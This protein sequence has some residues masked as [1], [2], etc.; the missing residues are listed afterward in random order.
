M[1]ATI[2]ALTQQG[3][4]G[5]HAGQQPFT[6]ESQLVNAARAGKHMLVVK[7]ASTVFLDSNILAA[8]IA[9]AQTWHKCSHCK[10]ACWNLEGL[11]F[12]AGIIA[13][14]PLHPVAA[15]CTRV[16]CISTC[17]VGGKVRLTVSRTV[18]NPGLQ[19]IPPPR[20]LSGTGIDGWLG[21]DFDRLHT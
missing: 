21:G 15:H 7:A 3:S 6:T 1:W 18:C 12:H 4:H 5:S 11:A 9:A 14:P 2:A 13:L 10:Q 20:G 16:T 17:R 19:T 8:A